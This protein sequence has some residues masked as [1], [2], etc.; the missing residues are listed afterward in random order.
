M[1]VTI[2]SNQSRMKYLYNG[3]CSIESEPHKHT[4][5]TVITESDTKSPD[6]CQEFLHAKT[7]AL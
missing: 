5:I 2:L 6:L 7:P 1:T 4:W 3:N